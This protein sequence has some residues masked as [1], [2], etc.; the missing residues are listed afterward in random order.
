MRR[1]KRLLVITGGL[2]YGQGVVSGI[3]A[4]CSTHGNWDYHV[5]YEVSRNAVQRCCM[6]IKDWNPDGIIAHAGP[7]AVLQLVRS[8]G[9][10]VVN[11]AAYET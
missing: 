8:L 3:Y 6:G 5:E 10:P 11:V 1:A 7:I 9:L 2:A 4:Y